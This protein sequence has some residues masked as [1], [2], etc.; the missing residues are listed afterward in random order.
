M[1]YFKSKISN[2]FITLIYLYKIALSPYMMRSC[3]YTPTCSTF[4]I[5]AIQIHGPFKGIWL[6]F[7]RILRCQPWGGSGNDPVP[8]K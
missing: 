7:K 1:N 6:G 8:K 5:Q 2:L 3:R 4:T